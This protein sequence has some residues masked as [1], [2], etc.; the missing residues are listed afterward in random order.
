MLDAL[1]ASSHSPTGTARGTLPFGLLDPVCWNRHAL[2]HESYD[3]GILSTTDEQIKGYKPTARFTNMNDLPVA[4]YGAHNSQRIVAQRGVFVIFG[5]NKSTMEKIFDLQNFP[6]NCLTKVTL[7]KEV[8]PSIR[9]S[10]L[11]HGI[12]ESVVF[13]DLEGLAKEIRRTFE[14]EV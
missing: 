4:L 5:K 1:R 7:D 3:Q 14:F 10:I 13:P 8:L 11:N 9:R 12:T 2:K 6:E